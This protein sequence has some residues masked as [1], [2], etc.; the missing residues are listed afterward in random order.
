MAQDPF[1]RSALD[2]NRAGRLTAEQIRGLH[3]DA[4]ESKRSGVLAG[5]TLLAVGLF[6]LWGTIA[7]RVPGSRL[8]SLAVGGAIA[9]VGGLLLGS[10]GMT[11][12]PRAAETASES[13]VLDVVEGPFRRERSDRQFAQDLAGS[14]RSLHTGAQYNYFLHV[15]DRRLSVGQPAYDAAPEDGIVRVY[16]LP[17]SDRIVNLERIADAPATPFE[18]RAA[19]MLRERFGAALED[20]RPSRA[21]A[22]ATTPTTLRAALLGLWQAQDLP[23]RLEFH[24]DGTVV[25]GEAGAAGRK[26]WD[27]LDV[28]R[29]RIDGE[30]RRVEVDGDELSL[31]TRGPTLRFRRVRN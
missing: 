21:N 23:L 10:R 6:I 3:I 18:A 15:G 25:G 12:G 2:D 28:G 16:L 24:A 19:A 14:T 13:T 8:Q 1:P 17:R 22:S 30:D 31:A 20:E 7:G 11:R 27:V 9:V 26:R 4:R 5:F 29:I